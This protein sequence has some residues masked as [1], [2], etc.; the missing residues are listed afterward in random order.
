[1][2]WKLYRKNE[3]SFS[4]EKK[5]LKDDPFIQ[6]IV[7]AYY[8]LNVY[9]LM[10]GIKCKRHGLCSQWTINCVNSNF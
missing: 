2:K 7:N 6:Q 10:W 8:L 9:G 5:R 4:N 1:M 3:T